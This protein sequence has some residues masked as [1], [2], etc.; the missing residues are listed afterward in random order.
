[1]KLPQ[2]QHQLFGS[3]ISDDIFEMSCSISKSTLSL[4]IL[5]L[6]TEW[7]VESLV[8]DFVDRWRPIFPKL[9]NCILFFRLIW[10][11]MVVCTFAL[12]CNGPLRYIGLLF[13]GNPYW[14]GRLSTFDPLV[15]I[16]CLVKRKKYIFQYSK[17]LVWTSLY[18]EGNRI[19]S[20]PL[21][22]ISW[23]LLNPISTKI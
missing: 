17:L 11:R 7:R 12:S 20:S 15:K 21:V 14:R 8:L 22:R 4:T 5:L 2:L 19:A 6:S 16:A 1:V 13:P 18:K 3:F 23:L 10:S 9:N